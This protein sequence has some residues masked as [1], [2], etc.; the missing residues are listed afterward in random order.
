MI[1]VLLA[2]E[3]VKTTVTHVLENT[4]STNNNVSTHV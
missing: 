4:I 2:Q 1:L 3:M